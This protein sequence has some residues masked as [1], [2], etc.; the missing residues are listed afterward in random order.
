MR[1]EQQILEAIDACRPGSDDLSA[2]ELA[3]V[4]AQVAGD[5]TLGELYRKVQTLDG[6]VAAAIDDVPV[7]ADLAIRLL[8]RLETADVEL[9]G[10]ASMASHLRETEPVVRRPSR[11]LWVAASA[12]A[13]AAALLVGAGVWLWGRPSEPLTLD[14]VQ[15]KLALEW[16]DQ[17]VQ[18]ASWQSTTLP[19]DYPPSSRLRL[20]PRGWLRLD[21]PQD[22]GAVAYDYTPAGSKN[23][24][25]LFVLH[26][27]ADG[28]PSTPP[29]QPFW[30]L[31]RS[32]AAWQEGETL[33]VL[34]VEGDERLYQ[35]FLDTKTAPLA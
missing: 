15:H 13:I 7:P 31:G 3:D 26:A 2:A 21:C 16:H 10:T 17:V 1:D 4:A 23:R 18:S 11:R 14:L 27:S 22:R 30:T 8:K 25:T 6:K 24:A 28:V 33:Y 12:S 5:R 29:Q 9:P 34:V 32:V 20:A 19:R 35:R